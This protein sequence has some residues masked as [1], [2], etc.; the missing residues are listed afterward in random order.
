LDDTTIT[1]TI[2]HF[3]GYEIPVDSCVDEIIQEE[4]VFKTFGKESARAKQNRRF[5][6]SIDAFD[7]KICLDK[8]IERPENLLSTTMGTNMFADASV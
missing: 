6:F 3:A 5:H 8:K 2:K 7:G 4:S 1:K